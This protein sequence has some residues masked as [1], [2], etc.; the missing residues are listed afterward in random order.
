MLQRDFEADM[1]Y[2]ASVTVSQLKKAV[3][4]ER[5]KRPVLDLGV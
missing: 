2:L 1:C 5:Q 3:E 4:E